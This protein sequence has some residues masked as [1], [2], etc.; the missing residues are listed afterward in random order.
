MVMV[1]LC[2]LDARLYSCFEL[3]C[4][5]RIVFEALSAEVV[6]RVRVLIRLGVFWVNCDSVGIQMAS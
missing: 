6:S 3:I 1:L 5:R 2:R 4:L